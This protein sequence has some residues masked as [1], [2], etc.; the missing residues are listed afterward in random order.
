M[1]MEIGYNWF[2]NKG[3]LADWFEQH[4]LDYQKKRGRLTLTAFAQLLKF[5]RGFL[6]QLMEGKASNMTYHTAWYVSVV[7]ND[8]SLMDILGYERPDLETQRAFALLSP[9]T[10]EALITVLSE[11]KLSGSKYD[12]PESVALILE[13]L[14]DSGVNVRTNDNDESSK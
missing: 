12:S 9:A 5:S 7:L 2:V 10:R 13:R 6:S 14:N 1:N 8:Y 4:Y 3:L 11:I